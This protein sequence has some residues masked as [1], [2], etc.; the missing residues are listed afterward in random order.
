MN[1]L[2]LVC[3]KDHEEPVEMT[4]DGNC[5]PC[6]NIPEW[7]FTHCKYDGEEVFVGE[8]PPLE[9]E[10]EKMNV[11]LVVA[12]EVRGSI[13]LGWDAYASMS[14]GP[15]SDD[16]ETPDVEAPFMHFE[17]LADAISY[18]EQ[19]SEEIFAAANQSA[20]KEL[21]EISRLREAYLF[22]KKE[23]ERKRESI[24]LSCIAH[25]TKAN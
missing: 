14:L 5:Y 8:G 7:G 16:E 22:A 20:Y 15:V 1:T 21:A 2:C 4:D 25:G 9:K 6:K 3:G 17:H 13:L 12:P 23:L 19:I 18:S 24:R 11:W 10:D